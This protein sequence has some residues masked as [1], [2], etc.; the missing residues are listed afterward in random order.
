MSVLGDTELFRERVEAAT[1]IQNR[2][3]AARQARDLDGLRA[4]QAD[5]GFLADA[6]AGLLIDLLQSYRAVEAHAD[7]VDLIAAMPAVLRRA[8]QVREHHAFALNRLTQRPEAED[9]LL[10]L[11]D[12]RGPD[13]ET[14]GLLGRVYKDQWEEALAQ[15]RARPATVLLDKAIGAYLAGFAADCRDHYPGINAVQLMY[16]RDPADERIAELLPVVRYSARQKALQHRA[17]F[18]DHATL[19]EVAVLENDADAAWVAVT[20]AIYARPERWQAQSTLDTLV[21]LRR[22]RE[23][24]DPTPSWVHDVEAELARVATAPPRDVR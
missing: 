16:L 6:S 23:H 5:L 9:I 18:W 4:V 15:G 21:R 2:L 10:Q 19:L 3:A 13:S 8:P 12:E 20:H 24:T 7:V 11:I 17:D 14:N 22:A 1:A